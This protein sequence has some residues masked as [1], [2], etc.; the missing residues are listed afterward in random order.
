MFNFLTLA[1]TEASFG[2]LVTSPLGQIVT[3]VLALGLLL[4]AVVFAGNKK[5]GFDV[6]TLTYSAISIAIATALS[7]L[8]IFS[9]PQGGSVT[10]FSMLFIIVVGYFFGLRTGI[11]AGI[12]YG[13]LQLIIAPYV[14]HPVQL[15]LDYPLAFGALGLSGIFA[16]SKYGL[17][18][19]IIVGT[20]GR[21]VFHFI[22]GMIFF[23]TYAPDGWDPTLYVFWYNFSYTGVEG[24]I[25]AVIIAIPL[26]S[27]SFARVKKQAIR[28]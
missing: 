7:F 12:V 15:L 13:L 23:F 26:V 28:V 6:K 5:G 3:A 25:T 24:I 19:G 8:K 2:D 16:N 4:L 9:L 17:M 22:S 11:L 14:I 20:M 1:S 10:F 18:K 27:A 21:F